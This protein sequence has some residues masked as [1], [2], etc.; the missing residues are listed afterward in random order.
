MR[1]A[2]EEGPDPEQNERRKQKRNFQKDLLKTLDGALPK[3]DRSAPVKNCAGP[4]SLGDKG[5]SL[6]NVLAD[7]VSAVRR[8]VKDDNVEDE[9]A[10]PMAEQFR[11]PQHPLLET[12]TIGESLFGSRDMFV[13]EVSMPGWSIVRLGDGAKEFYRKSPFGDMH[14]QSLDNLMD[15]ED[16]PSIVSVWEEMSSPGFPARRSGQRTAAVRLIY[17]NKYP[18]L[19][20]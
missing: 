7:T 3:E 16:I 9:D 1:R 17:F 12:H 20:S 4:R 6:H 11:P 8:L 2:L 19:G 15:W 14:R 18:C 10:G 13:L 5:R